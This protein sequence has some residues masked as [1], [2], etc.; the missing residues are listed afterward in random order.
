MRSTASSADNG[1][2][3]KLQSTVGLSGEFFLLS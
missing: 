2:G 1:D 3:I